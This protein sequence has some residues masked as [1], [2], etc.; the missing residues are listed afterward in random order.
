M[1]RTRPSRY[2]LPTQHQVA[3][4]YLRIAHIYRRGKIHNLALEYYLLVIARFSPRLH[5]TR[6][7]R[8][9]AAR[10]LAE[11][12]EPGPA[13]R[14]LRA[15][16]RDADTP[17]GMAC[18]AALRLLKMSLDPGPYRDPDQLLP[19][20]QHRLRRI[21]DARWLGRWQGL[22]AAL[23]ARKIQVAESAGVFSRAETACG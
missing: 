21:L 9:F 23:V 4:A 1:K 5:V 6:R 8:L 14:L 19:V 12:G 18:N 3:T 17:P 20:L 2:R 11:S 10:C 13:R 15:L 16:L 7:A 22:A